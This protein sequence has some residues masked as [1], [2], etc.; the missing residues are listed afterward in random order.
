[1]IVPDVLPVELAWQSARLGVPRWRCFAFDTV[2]DEQVGGWTMACAWAL[3]L[4]PANWGQAVGV[5]APTLPGLAWAIGESGCIVAWVAPQPAPEHEMRNAALGRTVTWLTTAE[6]TFDVI[7][8]LDPFGSWP[9]AE[10]HDMLA[11]MLRPRGRMVLSWRE[12]QVLHVDAWE[13]S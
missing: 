1:M 7:Y 3:A 6:C 12:D 5:V 10:R 9:G 4:A 2:A 8:Q 13:R 11:R